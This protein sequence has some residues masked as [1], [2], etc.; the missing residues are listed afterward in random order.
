MGDQSVWERRGREAA[1]NA[2]T[3]VIGKILLVFL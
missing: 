1:T 2:T 3:E